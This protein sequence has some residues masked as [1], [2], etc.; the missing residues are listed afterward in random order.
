MRDETE[1]SRP[2]LYNSS[3]RLF[4][5]TISRLF[6]FIKLFENLARNF[7]QISRPRP[8]LVGSRPSKLMTETRLKY[9]R[10]RPQIFS[11]AFTDRNKFV[12]FDYIDHKNLQQKL[13][14]LNFS[15]WSIKMIN[16]FMSSRQQKKN[17]LKHCTRCPSGYRF[18]AP[19]LQSVC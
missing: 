14:S 7:E 19:N 15:E 8:S 5:M 16:L 17:C 11:L 10:P 4:S 3:P 13:E 9:S 1:K 2:R 12:A 6:K 18:G